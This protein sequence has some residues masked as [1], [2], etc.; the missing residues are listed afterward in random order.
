VIRGCCL[1]NAATHPEINHICPYNPNLL[2]NFLW[3]SQ[4]KILWIG[5]Y[6]VGATDR[7]A[8]SVDYTRQI[9]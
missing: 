6:V 7:A 5:Q 3:I 9:F 4:A 2:T 8:I 1:G